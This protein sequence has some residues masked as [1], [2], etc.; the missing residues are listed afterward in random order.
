MKMRTLV[1]QTMFLSAS[2][3]LVRVLGFMMRIWLSREL[4]ALAMGLV[5]LAGSAQMLLITP[6]VSGLPAAMSRM[7]AKAKPA[8]QVRVLRSGMLLSL[9]VSLPL[10]MLAFALRTPICLWLGD[11]RTMPALLAYLP[12]LPILGLSCALNGYCYGAG[13]PVPPAFC[14]IFEQ[15][16]R[17]FLTIRLVSLLRGWPTMLRAAAP[18]LGTLAGETIALVLMLLLV[19]RALFFTPAQR[20]CRE[21]VRELITLALP[22]TGM[23]MVSSIMRTVQSVLIPARL[24]LS[25]LSAGE[26]LT[27][28]GMM[29]GMLMPILM[30]PSFITCS[31]SMVAS[32]ELTRR[33]SQG[34]GQRRLVVRVL[35][36][37]LLIGLAAMAGVF[38]LAPV[39]SGVLYRQAELLPL[40]RR[41][42]MMVPVMAL[43]QVTS[44]LMNALGL[45]S[46]SLR[47]SIGA[48]LLG[49]LLTYMLASQ[50]T[51]RLWGVILA[52][53]CAQAATLGFSLRTLLRS[54]P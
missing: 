11:V 38:F 10:T 51:L 23:R 5:E 25:G 35:S 17:F 48:N 4:G 16:V 19:G 8:G 15:I 39:F 1:I 37:T 47:I 40:L 33:Q 46:T 9:L 12:C 3:F 27:R 50:P 36:A 54:I 45:Q 49:T 52:M 30:L 24:Q 26:A 18:A 53:A 28:L 42:C 14:E 7:C 44:S 32:P 22:L 6:I 29:N 34:Q 21:T 2:H 13:K 41:C 43:C 31:L 20:G